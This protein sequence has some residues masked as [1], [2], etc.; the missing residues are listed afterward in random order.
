MYAADLRA[1]YNLSTPDALQI[2]AVLS[3]GCQAFVTN[4]KRLKRVTDLQIIVLEDL[5]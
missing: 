3:V 5:V 4:D 1:D 2:S